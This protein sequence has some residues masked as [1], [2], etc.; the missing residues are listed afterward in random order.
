LIDAIQKRYEYFSNG[1]IT[2]KEFIHELEFQ[3]HNYF[4][5]QEKW[6]TEYAQSINGKFYRKKKSSG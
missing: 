6:E 4:Q 5:I 2:F 3:N 1:L